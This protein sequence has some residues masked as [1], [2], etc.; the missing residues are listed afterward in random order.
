[1][2]LKKEYWKII[3]FKTFLG[4]DEIYNLN[5]LYLIGFFNT[6]EMGM[7]KFRTKKLVKIKILRLGNQMSGSSIFLYIAF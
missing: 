4:L 7:M 6:S 3:C 2:Y 5:A 1:M